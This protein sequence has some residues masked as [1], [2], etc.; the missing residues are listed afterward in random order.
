MPDPTTPPPLD[1]REKVARAIFERAFPERTREWHELS[2][3]SRDLW[4]EAADA[5]LA[6]LDLP[7]RDRKNRREGW[8]EGFERAHALHAAEDL[9][10]GRRTPAI[11]SINPHQE[12]PDAR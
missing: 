9:R 7:T 4:R 1:D 12:A 10:L 3:G 5:V 11:P 6:V 8:D 2:E